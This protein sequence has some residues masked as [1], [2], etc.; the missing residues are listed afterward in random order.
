MTPYLSIAWQRVV[1]WGVRLFTCAGVI[2]SFTELQPWI[3]GPIALVL[4]VFNVF[5]ERIRFYVRVLHVMPIPTEYVLQNRIGSLW[6]I[7]EH[8]GAQTILFGHLFRTQ[9]AAKEAYQLFRAWN[10]GDYIDRNGN[11]VLTLVREECARFT[12]LL[13]PGD[14]G[15]TA[16]AEHKVAEEHGDT[17]KAV[18]SK[19]LF[20]F[21]TYADYWKRPD[22]KALMERLPDCS[23]VLLN[24]YFVQNGE[25]QSV[26]KR[27]LE[28]S[29]IVV[30]DRSEV[31]PGSLE[32][33]ILWEG[34][35][36]GMDRETR[37]KYA[38]LFRAVNERRD[39]N[40]I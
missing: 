5:L 10:F 37:E 7:A 4:L 8:K 29:K 13:Y 2:V 24:C 20:W 25:P 27:H 39:A 26:A 22:M 15:V 6:G 30:I 9:R 17:T 1:K 32:S 3:A 23:N 35:W 11:I 33:C 21:V 19:I 12:I 34:P 40:A 36:S 31:A 18:V 14:R 38:P 16:H 28:L